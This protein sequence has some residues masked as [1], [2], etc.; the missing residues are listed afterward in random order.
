MR[1]FFISFCLFLT[2]MLSACTSTP[3]ANGG[4]SSAGS[5]PSFGIYKALIVQGN[6]ISKEQKDLLKPGLSKTQIREFLGTPLV[7]SVFHAER[8]DYVFIYKRQGQL[9]EPKRLSLFFKDDLIERIE[10]DNLATESEFVAQFGSDRKFSSPP[11]LEATP[12]QLEQFNA[13]RLASKTDA[14]PSSSLSIPQAKLP[15]NTYPP[16]EN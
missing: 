6:V 12:K 4:K 1:Q 5:S 7:N 15:L 8:W 2:I 16:L 3:E 14:R 10:S 9:S 11:A 13:E